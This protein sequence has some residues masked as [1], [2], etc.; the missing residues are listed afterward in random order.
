MLERLTPSI[1][2]F[3]IAYGR[4]DM[5]MWINGLINKVESEFHLTPV[6]KM[7]QWGKGNYGT[8]IGTAI[9]GSRDR[10]KESDWKSNS[11]NSIISD[12][13]LDRLLA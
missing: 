9:E 8:A 1:D 12:A 4:T 10:G 3:Y 7:F 13:E 2:K 5:R 11:S 6:A